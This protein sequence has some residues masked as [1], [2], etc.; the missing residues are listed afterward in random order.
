MPVFMVIRALRRRKKKTA[1]VKEA[2]EALRQEREVAEKKAAKAKPKPTPEWEQVLL[3]SMIQHCQAP[4]EEVIQHSCDLFVEEY[5]APFRAREA[6]LAHLT[7]EIK[8]LTAK[9][10][11]MVPDVVDRA[12]AA[13]SEDFAP[14]S[15][16]KRRLK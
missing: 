14:R 16:Q 4:T 10:Q 1:K 13:P 12:L 15:H 2:T 7:I 3:Y 11:A 5:N 8:A 6:Q 9:L